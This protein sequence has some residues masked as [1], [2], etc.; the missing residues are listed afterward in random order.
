MEGIISAVGSGS[1]FKF[2]VE[3][4][5]ILQLDSYLGDYELS[6]YPSANR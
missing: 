4:R 3:L 6:S 5:T 2:W 1:R